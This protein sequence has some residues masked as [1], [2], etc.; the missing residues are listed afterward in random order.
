MIG[1]ARKID[2][3][4]GWSKDSKG[5]WNLGEKW[6]HKGIVVAGVKSIIFRHI[7]MAERR[8]STTR[9][10]KL[11]IFAGQLLAAV[12]STVISVS[13]TATTRQVL[14][15]TLGQLEIKEKPEN[16]ELVEVCYRDSVLDQ[17]SERV[18]SGSDQPYQVQ[19]SW[20][21][22]PPKVRT[23]YRLFIREKVDDRDETK[24]E[25]L[26]QH[27]MDCHESVRNCHELDF[28]LES[29]L[30]D[31]DLCCLPTLSEQTLLKHL[32]ERF[33]QGR[34]YTYVGEILIAVNPFRFFPMYNPKFINAYNNRNLGSLPPHIFAIADV[35][36]HRMLREKKSQCVVISGESGSGKTEST[37][38][39]VHH[40]TALGLKTQ[41]TSV[42]KTILGVGPVLEVCNGIIIP[43]SDCFFEAWLQRFNLKFT[44]LTSIVDDLWYCCGLI[45][46]L[47]WSSRGQ[48]F[49]WVGLGIIPL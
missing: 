48:G 36:F 12:Q 22:L 7:S 26:R 14:R 9:Y 37:K 46:Y 19:Q 13:E 34:I 44:S 10:V 45:E 43:R 20:R 8:A 17:D 24:P 18:L 23:S 2:R 5:R 30:S 27:W 35:A 31:D 4:D 47:K 25:L 49:E 28:D 15:L 3:N 6:Q 41:A 1:I 40:L 38:L 42:E 16:F 33:S 29:K 32:E 39:I 11:R 21:K